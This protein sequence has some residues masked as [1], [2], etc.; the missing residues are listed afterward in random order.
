MEWWSI[1][2][3]EWW[4]IEGLDKCGV[5]WSEGLPGRRLGEGGLPYNP[6][7]IRGTKRR[8]YHV[9]D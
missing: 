8:S 2:V 3:V 5:W 1:G 7:L 9:F 6:T 4:S